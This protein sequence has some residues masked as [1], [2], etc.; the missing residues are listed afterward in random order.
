[1]GLFDGPNCMNCGGGE[2]NGGCNCT[3]VGNSASGIIASANA[4]GYS[5]S[6]AIN[7]ENTPSIHL[8][9]LGT[10]ANKL[11]AALNVHA[12]SPIRV[13]EEP[14]S[15]SLLFLPPPVVTAYCDDTT[16]E[17][18]GYRIDDYV[19]DDDDG[20]IG[21]LATVGYFLN[22]DGEVQDTPLTGAS[23]CCTCGSSSG[24]GSGEDANFTVSF[25]SDTS[26]TATHNLGKYPAVTILDE[27]G[28]ELVGQVQHLNTNVVEVTLLSAETGIVVC[29]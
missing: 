16:H 18:V 28:N 10:L 8:A 22:A 3:I 2:G 17:V 25:T 13:I 7:K 21:Y 4:T 23:P 26:I 9:G 14:V 19:Q 15:D 12:N 11:S 20:T 6:I 29:N 27:D 1:M 5:L 24:G